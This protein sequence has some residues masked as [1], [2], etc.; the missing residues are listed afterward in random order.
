ML[1]HRPAPNRDPER[2]QEADHEELRAHLPLA[3]C[4]LVEVAARPAHDER[5]EGEREV[6]A[7][8]DHQRP[9]DAE[10][11]ERVAAVVA[12]HQPV[13]AQHAGEV[14][15]RIQVEDEDERGEREPVGGKDARRPPQPERAQRRLRRAAQLGQGVGAEEQEAGDHEED[16]HALRTE[17]VHELPQFA[18]QPRQVG[19]AEEVEDEHRARGDGVEPVEAGE[20]R[21]RCWSRSPSASGVRRARVLLSIAL[22]PRIPPRC[23]GA[24]DTTAG[25]T[26]AGRTTAGRTTGTPDN[27]HAGQLAR[28]TTGRPASG[29][30]RGESRPPTSPRTTPRRAG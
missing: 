2:A 15:E 22:D 7:H 19:E 17:P 5:E 30:S 23:G 26:T 11:Q 18:V 13:E 8:L 12:L 10:A 29:A 9:R 1:S 20:V 25:R 28:R 16:R 14:V 4:G 24:D 27:W 3:M 21:S 6:E